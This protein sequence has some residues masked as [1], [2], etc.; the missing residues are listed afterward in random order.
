MT[1]ANDTPT[2]PLSD[3]LAAFAS[4]AEEEITSIADRY[5]ILSKL[6]QGGMGRVFKAHDKILDRDVAVK[7]LNRELSDNHFVL[8]FQQEARAA[9]QLKHPSIL[10]VLDFGLLS[11]RQPYMVM[12]WV[13]G[14]SLQQ[15]IEREHG[16]NVADA[17]IITLQIAEGMNHAH[18]KGIIH[19]DL[20][21]GNIMLAKTDMGDKALILDF[22]IAKIQDDRQQGMLTLTGQ[23]IGSP[24]C[25]SP[26]QARGEQLDSRTDVYSLGCILYWMLTGQPPYEGDSALAT[27]NMHLSEPIPS[28][29]AN[30]AANLPDEI[31]SII[32]KMLAKDK[33][34]RY[35]SMT[36]VKHAI[37]AIDFEPFQSSLAANPIEVAAEESRTI[38]GIKQT[39]LFGISACM[40]VI[41]AL[42]IGAQI[43]QERDTAGKT[44]KRSAQVRHLDNNSSPINFVPA[45]F[46]DQTMDIEYEK[47]RGLKP[48]DYFTLTVNS[49]EKDL[50][51]SLLEK[52]DAFH[53]R[54]YETT[55]TPAIVSLLE[56]TDRITQLRFQHA[57]IPS[58][59]QQRICS[60]EQLTE[61]KFVEQ[62]L[63]TDALGH[64]K[65]IPGLVNLQ[66]Y[67]CRL[68]DQ[69]LS[70]VLACKNLNVL[71]LNGNKDFSYAE[72]KNITKLKHLTSLYMEET[73]LQDQDIN[74]IS[75]IKSLKAL[76]LKGNGPFTSAA[77]R[78]LKGLNGLEELRLQDTSLDARKMKVLSEIE[79][80]NL[81][82]VSNNP[83]VTP[84]CIQFF[85]N[86]PRLRIVV[87][88]TAISLAEME[89]LSEELNV[90]LL[91]SGR[92]DP[93][94]RASN[95]F[96]PGS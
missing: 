7:L 95:L 91:M 70:N 36:D 48:K 3:P 61:L 32:N 31:D 20:K 67:K 57:V 13:N 49:T 68:Q 69:D 54:V 27:I 9:S 44:I 1:K 39:W 58:D 86:R 22:G 72:R 15:R 35:A 40:I 62:N 26:E 89:K 11:S 64:L 84:A 53:I 80:L 96:L 50:K 94:T 74:W 4:E 77:L 12:E 83:K 63:S 18:Q 55:I 71:H 17:L 92:A 56:D 24:P 6:G 47:A 19:R 65:N 43:L 66:I 14:E 73:S 29:S 90:G 25:M 85:R 34:E 87:G 45:N 60:L 5:T 79:S 16:L 2:S 52:P 21:P 8:R 37:E 82:E 93:L 76:G 46:V 81:L 33:F 75:S 28:A 41:V 10:C 23:I 78:K 59:L 30:T 51:Q 88:E 42:A 38:F